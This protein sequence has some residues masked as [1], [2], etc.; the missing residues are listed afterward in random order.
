MKEEVPVRAALLRLAED[1]ITGDRNKTYGSPTENFKNIAALLNVQFAHK[2]REEFTA[3][4]VAIMMLQVKLAR[5]IAQPKYDN[6]LDVA[7][8]A[9]CGA[10]CQEEINGKVQGETTGNSQK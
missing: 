10:E 9:A 2:L 5:M 6:W 8:Y 1:L 3:A 4:D 7:G